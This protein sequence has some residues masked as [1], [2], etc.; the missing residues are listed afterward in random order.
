MAGKRDSRRHSTTSFSKNVVVAGTSYQN[1]RGGEAKSPS[2]SITVLTSLVKKS[3]MK[4]SGVS[5][6]LEHGQKL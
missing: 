5:F 6:F 2:V 4:F 1:E 3:K